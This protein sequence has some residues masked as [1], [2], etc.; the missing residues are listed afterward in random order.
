MHYHYFGIFIL[1]DFC[2]LM[3][4]VG[5]VFWYS[6]YLFKNM[7]FIIVSYQFSFSQPDVSAK[8]T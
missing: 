2:R 6:P 8:S 3:G 7:L 4:I 5:R 1:T